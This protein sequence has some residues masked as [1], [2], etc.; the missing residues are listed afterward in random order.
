MDFCVF[1]DFTLGCSDTFVKFLVFA[2][3]CRL[4]DCPKASTVVS[5]A[6]EKYMYYF[7]RKAGNLG[8]LKMLENGYPK[9]QKCHFKILWKKDFVINGEVRYGVHLNLYLL[10]ST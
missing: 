3:K 2:F 6:S 10:E 5:N 9:A 7:C 4:I 8:K 1:N